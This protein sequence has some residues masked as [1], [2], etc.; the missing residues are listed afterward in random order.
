LSA[1]VAGVAAAD[2]V[3]APVP[4]QAQPDPL[5]RFEHQTIA[6]HDCRTN[7]NDPIAAQLAAVGALC[8]EM[9]VPLDYRHPDGRTISIAGTGGRPPTPRTS[10]ARWSSTPASRTRPGVRSPPRRPRRRRW[11]PSTT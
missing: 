6:W 11:A 9:T 10:W 7:P 3:A 1:V 4:A 5:H 2:V 8:G